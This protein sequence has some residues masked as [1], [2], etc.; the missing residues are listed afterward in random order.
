MN[1]III[2][3]KCIGNSNYGEIV[4]TKKGCKKGLCSQESIASS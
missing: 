4:P 1:N 3:Q 2:L